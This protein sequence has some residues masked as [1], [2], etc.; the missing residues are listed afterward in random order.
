MI[1]LFGN[2]HCFFVNSQK[3]FRARAFGNIAVISPNIAA[4]GKS[5]VLR[6]LGNRAVKGHQAL[7]AAF[8][9]G[10]N[11]HFF[12]KTFYILYVFKALSFKRIIMRLILCIGFFN[13][14]FHQ[15]KSER[16]NRRGNNYANYR[17]RRARKSLFPLK[18]NIFH[19]STPVYM[20]FF[21]LL[22]YSIQPP[23]W[24]LQKD[25]NTVKFLFLFC[26]YLEY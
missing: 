25:Y 17:N 19:S 14:L 22:N 8:Q 1:L 24:Q 2:G 7:F 20:K 5:R 15:N 10:K 13:M 12:V 3:I 9:I 18:F 11:S 16:N 6:F 21:P 23:P 26:S 4:N